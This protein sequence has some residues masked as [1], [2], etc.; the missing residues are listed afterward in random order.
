MTV[1]KV[2]SC[3]KLGLIDYP[4]RFVVDQF[5]SATAA[6]EPVVVPVI[7][8]ID[9]MEAYLS[10]EDPELDIC[11]VFL[12]VME[13]K[14]YWMYVCNHTGIPPK[15]AN[16][17]VTDSDGLVLHLIGLAKTRKRKI[18]CLGSAI[19]K[20]RIFDLETFWTNNVQLMV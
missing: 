13:A 17:W 11:R 3:N 2:V 10:P 9:K 7:T 19:H 6:G 15:A 8:M 1:R 18:K 4:P 12:T 16:F 5:A 14:A 20:H